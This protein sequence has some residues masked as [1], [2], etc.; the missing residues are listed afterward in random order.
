[1]T[2]RGDIADSSDWI[3]LQLRVRIVWGDSPLI[4][5][6]DGILSHVFGEGNYAL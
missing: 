6:Q 1:M 3:G 4:V 2:P 5:G